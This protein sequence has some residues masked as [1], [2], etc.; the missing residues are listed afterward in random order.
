MTTLLLMNGLCH[1]P[2]FLL[3]FPVLSS[4]FLLSFLL[5]LPSSPF[6]KL[7]PFSFPSSISCPFFLFFAL[8]NSLS[9][10]LPLF[11]APLEPPPA[12]LSPPASNPH[13]PSLLLC[14]LFFSWP[15]LAKWQKEV[16]GGWASC[17]SPMHYSC[18]L[19]FVWVQVL[20]CLVWG[21]HGP[22]ERA[23]CVGHRARWRSYMMGLSAPWFLLPLV[24]ESNKEW[25]FTS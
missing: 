18:A 3:Y 22:H 12:L 10:S 20:L 1:L 25:A 14:S 16:V 23:L 11:S 7:S 6:L 8:T 21:T 24:E 9:V 13:S 19:Q 15:V 2:L 4:S 5:A 17:I